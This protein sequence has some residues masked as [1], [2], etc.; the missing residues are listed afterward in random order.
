L[1]PETLSVIDMAPLLA[2]GGGAAKHAVAR[3]IAEACRSSGFF[4][5][6]GHGIRPELF[7][8]LEAASRRFFALPEA[9]KAE[10]AMVRGGRAWRGWFPVGNE[11]TSGVPDIK[12][13]LY[14]GTE[15]P[16]D[17]PRVAA[18]WPLHGANLWPRQV[19]ELRPA[20]LDYMAAATR[21]AHAL[22]AG[23]AV[24]LG[25]P[26]DYFA[27]TYTAEP[28]I[29][30]RIFN[31]PA[32]PPGDAVAGWGVGEHTDYGLLTLLAQDSHGGLQVK[33]GECWIDVPPRPATLVCNIGDMLDRLTGGAY[34]SA[35][36]R[37]QNRAAHDRL[38]FPLFFD[39]DFAAEIRPLPQYAA[40]P[41]T[42]VAEDRRRRWDGASVHE[43]SGTYGAYLLR[44]VGKVFPVL[45]QAVGIERH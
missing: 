5:V 45:G 17:H 16:P 34:R 36:H 30:F 41:D 13:G 8:R 43:F 15:L 32:G 33:E 6:V 11:L 14:L 3:A 40:P 18:G 37:V 7:A 39:P 22:I 26:S 44:K 19:P 27:R 25:L 23:V 28:T 29:L 42:V 35:P 4:Y 20:V 24:S 12:E 9:V 31:Y 38:S 10:I 2:A 1:T 21:A